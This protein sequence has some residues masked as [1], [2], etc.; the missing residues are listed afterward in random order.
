[1]IEFLS[2]PFLKYLD[3]LFIGVSRAN[4]ELV[5]NKLTIIIDIFFI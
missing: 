5:N 2:I 3:N 4:L 1:M